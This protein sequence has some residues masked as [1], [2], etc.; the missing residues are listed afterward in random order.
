[1]KIAVFIALGLLLYVFFVSWLMTRLRYQISRR[2]FKIT[3]F[4]ITLRRISFEQIDYVTKRRPAGLAE[5][6]SNT[7]RPSHRMLIIR[8]RRGLRRN[9][10]VTPRNRY[11][12]KANLERALERTD[13]GTDTRTSSPDPDT[14]STSTEEADTTEEPTKS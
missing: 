13:T 3:F 9:L 12:L 6:W 1:M 14:E 2:H 4:G 10:I 7:P 5:N 8:L 11:V